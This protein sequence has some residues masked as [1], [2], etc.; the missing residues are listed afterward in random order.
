MKKLCKTLLIL[1]GI[2]VVKKFNRVRKMVKRKKTRKKRKVN[3]NAIRGAIKS[4][5][6][7]PALK[8]GLIKKY[9]AKLKKLKR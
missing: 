3:L 1:D 5:K 8:R 4:P 7:P 2:Q 6:T 9:G